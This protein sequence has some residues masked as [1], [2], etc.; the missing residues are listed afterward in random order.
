MKVAF[1]IRPK[2]YAGGDIVQAE[3][4]KE[5]IEQLGEDITVEIL[6]TPNIVNYYNNDSICVCFCVQRNNRKNCWTY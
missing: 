6:D 5:F 2:N 3:K 4:T 1:C